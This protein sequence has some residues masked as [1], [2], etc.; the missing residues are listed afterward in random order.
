MSDVEDWLRAHDAELAAI[1]RSAEVESSV[2]HLV[3]VL[4]LAG[5]NDEQVYEELYHLVPPADGRR[6][7]FAGV[8]R[9]LGDIHRM[10]ANG[11]L[12]SG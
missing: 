9:V 5:I 1:A 11:G 6:P 7:P 3:A 10:T 2:V 4:V 8:A 12:H